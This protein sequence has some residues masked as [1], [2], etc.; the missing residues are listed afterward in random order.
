MRK[1]RF[2]SLLISLNKKKTILKNS[3]NYK[4]DQQISIIVYDTGEKNNN[5]INERIAHQVKKK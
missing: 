2:F 4:R 3:N 1:I 5:H